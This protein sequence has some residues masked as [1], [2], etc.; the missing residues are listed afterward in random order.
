MIDI[1]FIEKINSD[2]TED[3]QEA[4]LL[5]IDSHVDYSDEELELLT[6][7][8]ELHLQSN[9]PI[10]RGLSLR[11]INKLSTPRGGT[12]KT[13]AKKTT[14]DIPINEPQILSSSGQNNFDSNIRPEKTNRLGIQLCNPSLLIAKISIIIKALV[15]HKEAKRVF[16]FACIFI[17]LV[18]AYYYAEKSSNILEIVKNRDKNAQPSTEQ[19][20]SALENPAQINMRNSQGRTVLMETIFNYNNDPKIALLLVKA[21]A[22]VN[23]IDEDGYTAL[24]Y[25]AS[26]NEP[27]LTRS[28]IKAGADVNARASNGQTPL[29]AAVLY[30]PETVAVL[31]E[32]GA[33][34][35]ATDEKGFTPLMIAVEKSR[36]ETVKLLVNAGADVNAR[37]KNGATALMKVGRLN[38]GTASKAISLLEM[39]ADIDAQDN[40]GRT[41]LIS[42]VWWI[43]TYNYLCKG[44][45]RNYRSY[46]SAI[47]LLG[48]G[49]DG[50]IKDKSGKT[51]FDYLEKEICPDMND[52]WLL[53]ESRFKE[54]VRIEL[55]Y[56]SNR[57]DKMKFIILIF[58]IL[59]IPAYI[60]RIQIFA[61]LNN[62][63]TKTKKAS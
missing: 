24:M 15:T 54:P 55:K 41:A 10:L 7:I 37:S 4:L 30:G 21:G 32:S 43:S 25:A 2:K 26:K 18:L 27:E 50:R 49:A 13:T 63:M 61:C 58:I 3:V 28:L 11:A 44:D 34:L 36:E 6:K 12:E 60:Y 19:I 53:S 9:I 40:S 56:K 8:I 31:L 39:G 52:Y 22:D 14:E 33:N 1:E 5:I 45:S 57:N 51:A 23:A 29:M 48:L 20:I 16:V 17:M 59:L 35:E 62:W 47:A 46:E 38:F 42:A